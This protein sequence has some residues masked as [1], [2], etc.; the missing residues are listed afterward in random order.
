MKLLIL[1]IYSKSKEYDQMLTI[2]RSYLH[3]FPNVT[4]YFIDLRDQQNPIEIEDDFI[5]VKGEDTFS[6]ITYKTIASLEYAIKNI[7]FDYMIRTNMSTIINIPALVSYCSELRKT[8]IYT[9]GH[10]LTLDN[11]DIKNVIKERSLWGTKYIQGT[12]IIMSHD[13]VTFM[14]KNKSKIRFDIVDDVSIGIFID[15]YLPS[16]YYPD[17]ASYF[18]VTQNLKPSEVK[19]RYVFFRNRAYKNRTGDVKHMRIIRNVLYKNKHT[20]KLR[21]I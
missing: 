20:K 9:G 14:I 4:S 21:L 11:N 17:F 19:H 12:S 10:R 3:K 7:N 2:Q 1:V 8:K 5:Y 18:I 16:A 15:H 6:N 13:V